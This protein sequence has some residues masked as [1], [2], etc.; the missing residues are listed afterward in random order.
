MRLPTKTISF[1]AMAL[2]FAPHPAA[3]AHASEAAPIEVSADVLPPQPDPAPSTG[4]IQAPRTTID[5]QVRVSAPTPAP[6]PPAVGATVGQVAP[7][8]GGDV[9][10]V[11]VEQIA[12][13][14]ATSQEAAA[15]APLA[16]PTTA[17]AT[18]GSPGPI[19]APSSPDSPVPPASGSPSE[20]PS[21]AATEVPRESQGSAGATSSPPPPEPAP[22]SPTGSS[23][24]EPSAGRSEEP[25]PTSTRTSSRMSTSPMPSPPFVPSP[26]VTPTRPAEPVPLMTSPLPVPTQ[27][28][29]PS[30]QPSAPPEVGDELAPVPAPTFL[31]T[32]A[33]APNSDSDSST[34]SA[35]ET[36]AAVPSQTGDAPDVQA[37]TAAAEPTAQ[38]GGA[39]QSPSA[40]SPSP[41]A[42]AT[43]QRSSSELGRRSGL[44]FDSGVF[45]HSPDRVERYEQAVGRP[46]DVWQLAPQ[47]KEGFDTLLSETRRVAQQP[48]QGANID[49][50]IPLLS[51]EEGRQIGEA[52]AGRFPRA[53]VRPGWEF[54]LTGASWDWT[55]DQ[56]GEQAYIEQFRATVDGLREICPSCQITWNPNTGQGGVE[57]AMKAWPGD[58]YVD[59]IGID[60]YDW[61]NEDPI[62]GPGQ[63]DDWAQQARKLGKPVSLPEWGAHGQQGRGDNPAFVADVLAWAQR[64][65]DIVKMMSYFDEPESYIQNSVGDGQMPKVG[66]AL[67][68]GFAAQ[69]G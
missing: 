18:G 57:R 12:S 56:I 14:R 29:A 6:A 62:G 32:A 51:R 68:Q 36:S 8:V 25:V 43:Q 11:T 5:I 22:S 49:L 4:N 53:Y 63:L 60:A 34:S 13:P 52:I 58:S 59:V 27:A 19:P 55:T 15:A 1:S 2:A 44:P 38:V 23:V 66:Q 69:A 67:R 26:F 16:P 50:A 45:A 42:S 30:E 39:G 31:H 37:S 65:R 61:S 3:L 24:L 7:Q 33:P 17:T 54:N 47:R 20:S 9:V 28:P 35:A 48:P 46:V 64:N 21:P 10:R 41:A 40:S